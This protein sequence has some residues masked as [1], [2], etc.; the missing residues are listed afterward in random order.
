VE[1]RIV[2]APPNASTPRSRLDPE[3]IP[4]RDFLG[5]MASW[6]AAATFLFALLGVSRLPK[7]AVLPSPSKKFRVSV[8]ESLAAGVPFLPPGRGVAIY[9]DT[10]GVYAVSR[11]CTHLGCL[12]KEDAGG[13]LCPCHGSRFKADGS[14]VKGPAPSG[15]PWLAVQSLGGGAYLVDEG[16]TVP[17]GTKVS[18]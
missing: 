17:A 5:L 9:R 10:E 8:P 2:S 16:K 14:L 3:P 7:A 18:A 11:V 12:V 13:F 4:R 15:L 1:D 6:S